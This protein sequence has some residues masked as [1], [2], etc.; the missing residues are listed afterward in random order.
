MISVEQSIKQFLDRLPYIRSLKSELA[1]YHTLIPPGHFFSPIPNMSE[2]MASRDRVFSR[3]DALLGIDLNEIDQ[4]AQL[5]QFSQYQ[6]DVPF[7]DVSRRLRY[8][9]DNDTFSFDD[10]PILHFMLRFLQPAR[11]I[12]I[13]SGHS[14]ACMLDTNDLYLE[15]RTHFTFID[16]YADRLRSILLAQDAESA[17]IIEKPVQDVDVSLFEKLEPNDILFVDSSH[18]MKIGS[19][20]HAIMFEIL[21][22]LVPGVHVHF[23]DVRYPF[24]Y[25]EPFLNRGFYWNEAYL[26]RAFLQYN[27][28]FKI[29]FWLNYLLN[30]HRAE[31]QRW[32]PFLPID[33]S[34]DNYAGGSIWLKRAG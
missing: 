17:I 15:G 11:V 18:V 4:I 29:S 8:H 2:V 7:Y 10:G 9:I 16:P 32:L 12:E 1:R 31:V 3:N 6:E 27:S 30:V 21:P 14:S 22:R 20:L 23:H 34:H 25:F 13:G 24:Q 26:L 33:V 19:D 28:S 5:E